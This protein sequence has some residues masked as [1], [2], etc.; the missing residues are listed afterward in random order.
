MTLEHI[1]LPSGLRLIA[2]WLMGSVRRGVRGFRRFGEH[3]NAGA[4]ES[5]SLLNQLTRI[6][7]FAFVLF[8]THVELAPLRSRSVRTIAQRSLRPRRPGFRIFPRLR[9][10]A[11]ETSQAQPPAFQRTAHDPMLIAQRKLDALA[12][13][14]A[15]PMPY[16]RRMARQLGER[17]L[18]MGW[19]PPGRP[20]PTDRR[21]YWEEQLTGWREAR[22]QLS[23]WRRRTFATG[24]SA[25]ASA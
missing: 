22:H 10:F 23:A 20:P 8:A 15:N 11:P 24:A 17:L 3:A 25:P 19:R 2:D 12:R 5:M 6:L 18:V 14:L 13:V 21:A 7:R 9:V 1:P 16:V 4:G